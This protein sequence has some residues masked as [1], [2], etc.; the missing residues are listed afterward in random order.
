M[1]SER[2]QLGQIVGSRSNCGSAPQPVSSGLIGLGP[3]AIYSRANWLG[4]AYE[5][6]PLLDTYP[7][8][9]RRF[10]RVA[11]AHFPH[12]FNL[13]VFYVGYS[14]KP[15]SPRARGSDSGDPNW[16]AR[17]FRDF[18]V[19]RFGG[20]FQHRKGIKYRLSHA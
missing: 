10:G 15:A 18:W 4:P 3:L 6:I 12:K 1:E 5:I 8:G 16:V 2:G 17:V 20:L 14:R 13:R 9:I 11:P 7:R 19:P